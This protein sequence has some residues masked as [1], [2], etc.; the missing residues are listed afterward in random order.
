[1]PD[2]LKPFSSEHSV[3]RVT[4]FLFFPQEILKPEEIFDKISKDF[5]NYVRRDQIKKKKITISLDTME[6]Q[7]SVEDEVVGFVLD[8]FN[9]D[10][11]VSTTFKLENTEKNYFLSFESRVYTRWE[12]FINSYVSDLNILTQYFN[13]F[14]EAISLNYIDEFDWKDSKKIPTREIFNE[15]SELLP[16]KFLNAYNSKITILTQSENSDYSEEKTD[17]V[18]SNR[19]KKVVITHHYAK[20]LEELIKLTDLLE[21]G[22][23]KD[24]FCVAHDSNKNMLR[25]V[26]KS[27]IKEKIGLI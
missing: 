14:I 17:I 15:E 20:R 27:E 22:S 25:D 13:N 18:F 10:G 8:A 9:D 16:A 12:N 6:S 19:Y 3:K 4:A 7:D 11:E 26:L 2:Q 5:K 23:L 21:N 1:M 24:L